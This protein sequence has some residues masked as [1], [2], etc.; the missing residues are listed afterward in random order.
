[1]LL[2]G[3][4]GVATVTAADPALYPCKVAAEV[5]GYDPLGTI[6]PKSAKRMARFVQFAITASLESL[7]DARLDLDNVDRDRFGVIIGVGIGDINNIYDTA[8]RFNER[9]L[10]GISPFFIPR[11]IADMA[12]GQ[13]SINLKL[14]GPN[15]CTTSACSSATHAIG[16]A[17]DHIR[18]GRADIVLAGGSEAAIGNLGFGGFCS[19]R[20][21]TTRECPPEESSR[22]F[23]SLRDGF[24]MGEGCGILLVE[25]LKHA[26]AR[27]AKI[28][29]ELVGY[30][31]TGDGYHLTAPAPGG[32]GA[33]RAMRM[34]LDDAGLTPEDIDYINAH[35]T[36]TLLNDK[37]ETAAI[38]TLFGNYAYKVA[39]SST[40]SMTGHGLGAAGGME[41]VATVK[42]IEEGIV[43]R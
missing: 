25:E 29:C 10:K 17:L 18:A 24:I 28:Y 6:D 43:H 22:P 2:A 1:S 37:F 16:E 19:A 35:G 20:A 39:I 21:L 32:E 38:K 40:K 5:K 7:T 15:F 14:K 3:R 31:L 34:A 41:A 11:V 30:G 8:S 26:E 12:A 33:M 4:S 23:D 13:V 42:S 9:G 36:S 27:G